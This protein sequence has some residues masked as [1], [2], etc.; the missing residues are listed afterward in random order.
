MRHLHQPLCALGA[1]DPCYIAQCT[2][3]ISVWQP[4]RDEP[5]VSNILDSFFTPFTAD[6]IY[7]IIK[8][9]VCTNL[10]NF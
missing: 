7:K 4:Q 2:I 5:L 6:L 9:F 1:V 3:Q 8:L 10:Y